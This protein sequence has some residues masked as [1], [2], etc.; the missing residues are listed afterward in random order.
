MVSKNDKIRELCSFSG[1]V[2]VHCQAGVSR[3][4][5]IVLAFLMMKRSMDVLE[6]VKTVREKREIFPN[7]GF[8][9]QLC[10]LSESLHGENEAS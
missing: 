6:A 8:L 2:Y 1:R 10:D 5:S 4:A 3:S 7:D 9:K